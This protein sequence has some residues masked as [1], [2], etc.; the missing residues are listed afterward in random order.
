VLELIVVSAVER[1]RAEGAS[2][3]HFGF[4][5]FTGM[6]AEHDVPGGSWVAARILQL[7]ANH[8]S[9]A[10][11]AADQLAY[12]QKWGPDLVQ[13]EYV[14]FAGGVRPG[15][16]WSLLRLTNAVIGPGWRDRRRTGTMAAWLPH[17]GTELSSPSPTTPSS[18]RATT[19][20]RAQR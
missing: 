5:P 2:H 12:K 13:P 16:V 6:G 20:S 18:S 17:P 7:L 1:F 9:A 11:P 8:G 14:A 10:Y 15:A 4:T 19:T 3:L